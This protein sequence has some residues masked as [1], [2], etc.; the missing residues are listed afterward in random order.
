[1]MN[2]FFLAD[3]FDLYRQN[4]L[5]FHAKVLQENKKTGKARS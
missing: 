2:L 5:Q 3:N 1:M 4:K